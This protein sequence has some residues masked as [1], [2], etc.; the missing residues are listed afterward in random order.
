[1]FLFCRVYSAFVSVGALTGVSTGAA[2]GFGFFSLSFEP[3]WLSCFTSL[4]RVNVAFSKLFEKTMASDGHVTTQRLQKVQVPRSY[5]YLSSAFF[6]LPS[7]VSFMSEITFIVPFG[8]FI[9]QTPHAV[10][11]CSLFSS[12]GITSS[13]LK[14]SE[15]SSV[16]LFSG[17]WRVT[18]F[19][20]SS[21]HVTESPDKRDFIPPNKSCIYSENVLILY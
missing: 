9:S 7:G 13:A 1:M 11:A 18:F 3:S 21:F 6:F 4:P 8:Q 14:R 17:Y 12:C 10:Q 20:Q 16:S 5:T 2:A 19:V 15:I